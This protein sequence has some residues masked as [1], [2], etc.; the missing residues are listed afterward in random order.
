VPHDPPVDDDMSFRTRRLPRPPFFRRSFEL[1]SRP[2]RARVHVTAHGVYE[3]RLNGA[4]VG[5]HELAPGWT[6]YRIRVQYQTHDVTDQ[7]VEGENVLGAIVADGWWSGFY[8][9]NPRRAGQHYGTTPELLAQL[10]VDFA[11][12]SQQVI[13]TDGSWRERSGPLRFADLLMGERYEAAAE[14][15]AWDAPG[16]DDSDWQPVRITGTD[17]STLVPTLDPPVRVTRELRP[18]SV[19]SRGDGRFIVDLG[20]NMVGRVRLTVRGAEPGRRIVL[21]HAEVLDGGELYVTNLRAAEATDTYVAAGRDAEV[22]EPRFTFHGFR[23][24]EVSGYPGELTAD[25]LVGRVL[26]SDTP[27][28]GTFSCSDPM[29]RQLQS[30]IEWG[31]RGNFLSVPTDCPQRDERLGWTADAQIFLPTACYNADV[32]AFFTKW[33]QDVRD[34][35]SSEGWVTDVAPA[36]AIDRI[37]APAWGDAAT[38]MPWHLY[39]TYGDLRFLS[40]SFD[41]MVAWVGWIERHNPDLVWRKAV[42]AHYGDWLQVDA[43]TPR[44]VLA[45]AYFALDADLVARAAEVLGR[46]AEADRYADLA[47]RIRRVFVKEFVADDG[48][49]TGGTQ[50]CYLLALAFDLLPEELVAMAV[51]HLVADIEAHDRHLTTGF[52]GVAYLCPTLTRFGHAELAHTLLL[53]DS[54]PSWGYS[55]RHGA[56]TIWERWDGWTEEHGFQ[57]ANMNS[58]NHYSLGS[59]GQWLYSDVAGIDQSAG[60]VGFADLVVR[61][62][63]DGRLTWAEGSYDSPR[64]MVRTRWERHRGELTLTVD[65]PP[66]A[67]ATVH[68]PTTAPDAVREG[69]TPVA[70]SAGVD[71]LGT[72]DGSLLCRVGSGHYAFTSTYD[73]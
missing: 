6:D 19:E 23:Y 52:V 1:P 53:Q 49:I 21:R 45:T 38:I 18:V 30:N 17:R 14:L 29:V 51:D 67:S 44:D 2:V 37:G 58:F 7:L 40:D 31:Q 64:G 13:A 59:V 35:Q 63:V 60:S 4:K 62:R 43:S 9:Q 12:G 11:D 8:G 5:D 20:Q 48:R 10:V 33:M 50:T 66:G 34:T 15:G 68:V 32:S 22:F 24:V 71:V 39:R 25:D 41:S 27:D 3:L 16:Y 26:Q 73:I 72:G 57:S 42:G 56:T 69:G 46:R 55:I 61:P 70:T 36:I 47:E 65:V 28:V 54:Y